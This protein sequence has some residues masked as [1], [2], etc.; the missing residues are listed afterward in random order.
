MTDITERKNAEQAL[1]RSERKYRELFENIREGVYQTSPDGRILAANPELLRMLGFSNQDELNVPGVV[2]DTFVETGLHQ[3]LRDRL[4]RD[5]SY[6]NVEFQL[7]TRDHRIIT[8]RENARVVR[9][10]NGQVLYYEGTLT[11]ITEAIRLEKQLRQA[12]QM[13]ALGRLAGGIARDFRGIGV[14][15]MSGLQQ[16]LDALP[17]ESPVRAGLAAVTRSLH[18]AAALTRQIL[19]FS[20]RHERGS[21]EEVPLDVNLLVTRLEPALVR[22]AGPEHELRV[23]LAGDVLPVFADAGHL[24]Q[25]VSGFVIHA[26]DCGSGAGKIRLT[27][28]L[29]AQTAGPPGP[30]VSLTVAGR[31][32]KDDGR[33][34]DPRPWIGM[35][36][37]RAILAQY[38][39][40]MTAAAEP[41]DAESGCGVRYSL[42]LPLATG[43]GVAPALA[44][45]RGAVRAAG[46]RGAADP[47]TQPRHAGAPGISCPDGGKFGGSGANRAWPRGV[48]RSDYRLDARW[49]ERGGAG[50][51]AARDASGTAR[52]VRRGLFRRVARR[53]RR[54][55]GDGYSSEAVLGRFAGA[56]GA[57]AAGSGVRRRKMVGAAG[58]EPATTGLEGRCSIQLSYAPIRFSI[59]ARRRAGAEV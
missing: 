1:R 18:G 2:R 17:P 10:E 28:A 27:T 56:E 53:H 16:A 11:D 8:V 47:G 26:R 46:G 59:V 43:A 48:R 9:D 42:Y 38:G 36:T 40:T 30:M 7:R 33:E 6:A 49:T 45:T 13:E 52:A 20:Q 31:A 24:Q 54:A 3:S 55:G 29:E 37:T 4:E 35:E 44:R 32:E 57:C 34:E 58:F 41:P 21:R 50:A 22:L 19:D 12:Q 15:M 5:G 14:G 25:I 23:S 39:G 51:H